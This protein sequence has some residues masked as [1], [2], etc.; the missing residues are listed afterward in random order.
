VKVVL[1]HFLLVFV[2]FEER[3]ALFALETQIGFLAVTLGIGLAVAV[4]VGFVDGGRLDVLAAG[5]GVVGG[6]GL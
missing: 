1:S 4:L 5:G 2:T 6:E 3:V